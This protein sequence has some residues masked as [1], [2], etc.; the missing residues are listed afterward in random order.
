M[1]K[2]WLLAIV[3]TVLACTVTPAA[4]T[5]NWLF[6]VDPAVRQGRPAIIVKSKEGKTTENLVVSMSAIEGNSSRVLVEKPVLPTEDGIR[7]EAPNVPQP[8]AIEF[9]VTTGPAQQAPLFVWRTLALPKDERLIKYRGRRSFP[10]PTDFDTYWKQAKADLAKVPL[11]PVIERV[12]DKDTSSGLLHKVILPSVGG[13]KIV[14]WYYLPRDAFDERGRV[15]S[16][17]PATIIMPGYGAEEP[18]I[19]RTSS[20]VITLSV[21]PRHHGP[22]REF[23]KAPVEHML[24]NIDDPDRF[25]YQFAFLDCLRAAE[26]LFARAEVDQSRI[27]AEGGS[28]GGLFALALGALE[29]RIACVVSNVTAFSA[30]DDGML[31]SLRGHQ[32]QYARLLQ[33]NPTSAPVI[34]RSLAYIDGANL[35]TRIRCPVQINMGDTDPVCNYVTGLVIYNQLPAGVPREYH[36]VANCG[37]AVPPPM[38]ELNWAWYKRWLKV[39]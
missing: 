18:P 5:G 33:E 14:C 6:S 29:P 28:Q 30:F 25:Y 12:P 19:D 22:S 8:T 17:Y 31:L 15:R 24:W 26:F 23:W 39:R 4:G 2:G 37:H 16:T 38:R 36:V 10:I 35:A 32:V 9:S 20:G 27:A 34:R 13:I 11:E 1:K 3:L 21:N 7:I